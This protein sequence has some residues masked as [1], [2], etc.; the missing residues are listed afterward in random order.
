MKGM[1]FGK[2]NLVHPGHIR[3]LEEAKKRCDELVVVV[4]TD[5][6]I[7]EKSVMPEEQRRQVVEALKPVDKAILGSEEDKFGVLSQEKP[8]V[9]VL[10]PDQNQDESELKQEREKRGLDFK[11][12]R[13]PRLTNGKFHKASKIV[14]HIKENV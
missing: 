11:I 4:A 12:V 7:G 6:T 3:Y 14:E 9:V 13:V 2:F 8:D 1:A 5:K 10:G